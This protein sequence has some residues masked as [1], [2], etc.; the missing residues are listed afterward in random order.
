MIERRTIPY[1]QRVIFGAFAVYVALLFL[2]TMLLTALYVAICYLC[3]HEPRRTAMVLKGYRVW[4][5]IFLPLAGCRIRIRGRERLKGR[6]PF[7]VVANHRSFVDI[8]VMTPFVPGVNK[9]LAKKEFAS[10]PVFSLIYR[11]GSVL[12]DRKNPASRAKSYEAM[13]EVLQQGM[14]MI[15]YPEGT[16]NTTTE[17][18]RPFQDGAFALAIETQR[19]IVPAVLFHTEKILPPGAGLYFR[20]HRIELHFLPP[21]S[22]E[23]YDRNQ[24]QELKQQVFSLMKQYYVQCLQHTHWNKS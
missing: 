22:V 9:T 23:G 1:W 2:V 24:V 21:V 4:M 11:A 17:P 20:P 13:K 5:S 8:L 7:V 18:L 16:R 6:G 10:I 12:V 15:I 3:F 19:P 14:H